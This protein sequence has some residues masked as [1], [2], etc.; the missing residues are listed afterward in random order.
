[1]VQVEPDWVCIPCAKARGARVP[2]GHI[3]TS[4]I[5]ICGICG[6]EVEVTEPRDFG[7]TRNLLMIN[8]K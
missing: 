4:H 3:Y 1:M 8:K 5:G 7:R 6:F 2:D